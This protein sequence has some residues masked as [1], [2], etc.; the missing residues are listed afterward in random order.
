MMSRPWRPPSN[1]TNNYEISQEDMRWIF[2]IR[3][4]EVKAKMNLQ[5]LYNYFEFD[6]CVEEVETQL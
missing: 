5:G 2:K 1:M 6:I 4:R 3:R